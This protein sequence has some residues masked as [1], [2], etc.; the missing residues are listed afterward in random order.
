MCIVRI[1]E[2][3]I[4]GHMVGMGDQSERH[5]KQDSIKMAAN[6]VVIFLLVYGYMMGMR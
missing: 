4:M 5:L 1:M 2:C 6:I 3:R